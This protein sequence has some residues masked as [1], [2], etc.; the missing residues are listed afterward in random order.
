MYSIRMVKRMARIV[1]SS[2][3]IENNKGPTSQVVPTKLQPIARTVF[4]NLFNYNREPVTVRVSIFSHNNFRRRRGAF[5]SAIL[6]GRTSSQDTL[7]SANFFRYEVQVIVEASSLAKA[8][9]VI[10]TMFPKT[11]RRNLVAA[12]RLVHKEFKVVSARK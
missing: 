4:V 2:G 9:N 3:V 6:D 11:L 8:K 1:Y 10:L 12:Q 7:P 5:S